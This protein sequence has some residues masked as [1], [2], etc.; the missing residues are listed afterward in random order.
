MIINIYSYRS[1]L[2]FDEYLFRDAFLFASLLLNI[3]IEPHKPQK[4]PFGA[5]V[6][7]QREVENSY[8]R[9][10]LYLRYEKYIY[11]FE[12]KVASSES[13]AEVNRKFNEVVAQIHDNHYGELFDGLIENREVIALACVIVNQKRADEVKPLH[14]V[15]K[16]EEVKIDL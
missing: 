12:F 5:E 14:K 1:L 16:L 2:R 13:E 9:I 7:V 11:A 6:E 4:D 10:D 3:V 15:V 8:G